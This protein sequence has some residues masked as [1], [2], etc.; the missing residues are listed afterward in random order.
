MH[1]Y[2]AY[3]YMLH[4]RTCCD[5]HSFYVQV[6]RASQDQFEKANNSLIARIK[7]LEFKLVTRESRP[8]DLERITQLEKDVAEKVWLNY[9]TVFCKGTA[10]SPS[11]CASERCCMQSILATSKH[12][13]HY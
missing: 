4:A 2:P 11:H 1:I 8:E 5:V 3:A 10:E 7:E 12:F 13:Y 6:L 9:A